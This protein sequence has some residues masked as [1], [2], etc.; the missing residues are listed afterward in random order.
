MTTPFVIFCVD[1]LDNRSV[2]PDFLCE[3]GPATSAG[4]IPARIDHDNLDRQIDAK[5]ALRRARFDEAGGAVY[6]GWMLSAE[7]YAALFTELAERNVNLLTTPAEYVACH[8]APASY[9]IFAEWMP[10][11]AWIDQAD[12]DDAER[13]AEVLAP[14]G[15]SALIIKDWVKS[16]AAGYWSEACYIG[17]ASDTEQVDRVITRFRELQGESLVGGVVFKAYVPLLPQNGPAYEWRA[18]IVDRKVVDCRARSEA[19]NSLGAPPADV[20]ERVAACTPSSFAS[21][22]FGCDADGRWWL[23]EVGDGQVSGLPSVEAAQPIFRAL[24]AITR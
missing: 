14:F 23:L 13:R 1:P 2:E 8:H 4:F 11:T 7:A 15:K 3:V 16:Q 17:D 24:A 9:A 10:K 12:L 6:R 22:D 5:A 20:I 18:F 21:A 19:A